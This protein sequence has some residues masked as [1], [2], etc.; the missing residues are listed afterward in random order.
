MHQTGLAGL[1]NHPKAAA[2]RGA[3]L[4]DVQGYCAIQ[5]KMLYFAAHYQTTAFLWQMKISSKK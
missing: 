2:T 4:K 1:I 3:G 5:K